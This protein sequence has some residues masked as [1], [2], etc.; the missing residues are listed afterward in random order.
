MP[1]MRPPHSADKVRFKNIGEEEVA[2]LDLVGSGGPL[3]VG[4]AHK[5][6]SQHAS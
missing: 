2:T 1:E 3:L 4:E 5:A 6:A